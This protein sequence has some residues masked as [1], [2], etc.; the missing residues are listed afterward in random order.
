MRKYCMILYNLL[1]SNGHTVLLPRMGFLDKM[2]FFHSVEFKVSIWYREWIFKNAF[3]FADS[4]TAIGK[5]SIEKE[6]DALQTLQNAIKKLR[7]THTIKSD[8]LL[9]VEAEFRQVDSVKISLSFYFFHLVSFFNLTFVW[10]AYTA[11]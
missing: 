9:N 5:T 8:T 4:L 6:F 11:K 3:S 1:W 2:A 7:A 10:C